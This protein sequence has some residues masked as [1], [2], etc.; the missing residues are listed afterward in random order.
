MVEK[1]CINKICK[2]FDL[3]FIADENSFMNI[4]QEYSDAIPVHSEEWK[5]IHTAKYLATK[6][7]SLDSELRKIGFGA[8]IL[9][10]LINDFMHYMWT[11]MT[12]GYSAE[13]KLIYD[14]FNN[15]DITKKYPIEKINIP[16]GDVYNMSNIGKKFISVDMS[17]AAYQAMYFDCPRVLDNMP[18]WEAYVAHMFKSFKT[19]VETS[20]VEVMNSV[21]CGIEEIFKHI[22]DAAIFI[23]EYTTSS[24]QIR[25]VVFGKTNG[26]RLCHIEKYVMQ[27][28]VYKNIIENCPGAVAVKFCNDEVIFEY[29]DGLTEKIEEIL[30]K[31]FKFKVEAFTVEGINIIQIITD[32]NGKTVSTSSQNG[33]MVRQRIDGSHDFSFKCCPSILRYFA[34]SFMSNNATI[35][36][37]NINPALRRI[38]VNG[39]V[40]QLVGTFGFTRQL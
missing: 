4:L 13:A 16:S 26:A 32:D 14:S 20:P 1:S 10:K 34:N 28:W 35:N 27:K 8:D 9:F 21:P 31:F 39:F 19:K 3:P 12:G 40:T 25:Q 29:A 36:A 17:K 37:E 22:S 15:V 6:M 23:I 24:R 30:P 7:F 33:I 18:T 2:D 38:E 11:S 5:N